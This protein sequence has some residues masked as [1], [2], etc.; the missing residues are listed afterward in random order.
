[1]VSA[2]GAV[3]PRLL[4]EIER[5]QDRAQHHRFTKTVQVCRL[6]AAP[7]SMPSRFDRDFFAAGARSLS[8][9]AMNTP[10]ACE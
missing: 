3:L 8:Q 7:A 10:S 5:T 1:M 6:D 9:V 4:G 2:T